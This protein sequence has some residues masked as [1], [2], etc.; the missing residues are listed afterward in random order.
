MPLIHKFTIAALAVLVTV[1]AAMLV[2]H[3]LSVA[4]VPATDGPDVLQQKAFDEF[5]ARNREMFGNTDA[6][7]T[8]RNFDQALE[9]IE[10]IR[11]QHPDNPQVFVY[12]ARVRYAQGRIADAVTNYRRA[13]EMEPGYTDKTTPLY[14]GD[15]INELLPEA[16]TKLNRE[17]KLKPGDASIR[18]GLED[19]YYLQR[20]IAGGCE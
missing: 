12:L 3:N 9:K 11:Q 8:A 1:T 15:R 16:R 19:V 10:Q 18:A 2:Q 7:I 6:L 13:V 17:K 5:I 14:I 20:R 4:S